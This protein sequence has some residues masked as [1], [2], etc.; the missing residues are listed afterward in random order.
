MVHNSKH[1]DESK[2]HVK[3]TKLASKGTFRM[4][5]MKRKFKSMQKRKKDNWGVV[6]LIKL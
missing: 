3:L 2:M 1:T 6:H 5:S 4:V